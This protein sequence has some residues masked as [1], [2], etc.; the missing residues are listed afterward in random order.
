MGGTPEELYANFD[1]EGLSHFITEK[2]GTSTFIKPKGNIHYELTPLRTEG[3]YG[4]FRH[5]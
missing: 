2:F 5:P 4:D 3:A 1:T